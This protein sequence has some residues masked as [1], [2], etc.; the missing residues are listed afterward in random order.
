MAKSKWPLVE[1]KLFEI[2]MWCRNGM[3][4]KDIV[5]KLN[6]SVASFEQYKNKHEKLKDALKKGKE[7]VDFEVEDSLYKKC[8]G[9]YVEED[10]AF[11]CKKVFYDDNNNRCESEE[12][13]TVKVKTF[14]PA[15]TTAIAIW[16][17]N[18]RSSYWRRNS[19]KEK[20]DEE[21]FEHDKKMDEK[22]DW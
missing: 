2:E 11:K 15:D 3:L 20:L 16:L 12:V 19:N 6:I 8:I 10:K 5:K 17:N 4:E 14:I 21:K 9:S 1:E 22:K 7:R 18:R 13:V